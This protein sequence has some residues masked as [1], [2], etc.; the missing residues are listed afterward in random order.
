MRPVF[1]CLF[2]YFINSNTHFLIRL[3][4]FNLA[5]ILIFLRP[6]F[7]GGSRIGWGWGA[8]GGVSPGAISICCAGR[9]HPFGLL[10]T[11]LIH[12]RLWNRFYNPL[13]SV[14]L[15]LLVVL[16]IY[17][18]FIYFLLPKLPMQHAELKLRNVYKSD[19]LFCLFY[20]FVFL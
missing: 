14:I 18:L 1:E 2:I 19:C 9:W 6:S 5:A 3:K 12:G 4:A 16:F 15:P 11:C 10:V 20:I 7:W 13:C 8:F 17:L